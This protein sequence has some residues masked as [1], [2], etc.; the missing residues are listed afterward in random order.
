MAISVDDQ[1]KSV[2]EIH[3]SNQAKT[4]TQKD[5]KDN[6][7]FNSFEDEDS[8]RIIDAKETKQAVYENFRP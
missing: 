3:S 4:W 1:V 2:E 8:L 7:N 5:C 6:L